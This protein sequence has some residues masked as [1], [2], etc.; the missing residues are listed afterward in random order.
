MP[1]DGSAFSEKISGNAVDLA[2]KLGMEIILLSILSPGEKKLLPKRQ[3]YLDSQADIMQK[4]IEVEAKG[5][6]YKDKVKG[7][8]VMG[9]PADEIL[10][11]IDKNNIDIVAMATHGRSGIGSLAMG[12]VA[13]NVVRTAKVPVLLVRS[14]ARK[15]VAKERLSTGI[16]LVPLDGSKP[17]ESV[18]QPVQV[19]AKQF[20]T[21]NCEVV[22]LSVCEPS[23]VK[24][25][26]SRVIISEGEASAGK[27]A[28]M[29]R[30]AAQQYLAKLGKRIKSGGIKVRNE[31]LTGDPAEKITDYAREIK[32][33]LI[34]MATHGRTGISRLAYGSVAENVIRG[35]SNPIFL[36]R[37]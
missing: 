23:P 8:V 19:L 22:L 11:Y 26:Y 25:G 2:V 32:A 15:Q 5:S 28:F 20:G 10:R 37:P 36:V 27:E 24:S 34:A 21:E 16:I 1:L 29:H 30:M 3:E 17:G 9:Q 18:L 4:Q 31:V 6:A 12:S 7:E 14:V 33:D 35:I 13:Y